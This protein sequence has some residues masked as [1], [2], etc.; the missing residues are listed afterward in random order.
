[1]ETRKKTSRSEKGE[2]GRERI[3]SDEDMIQGFPE[4]DVTVMRPRH[5][6]RKKKVCLPKP[7]YAVDLAPCVLIWEDVS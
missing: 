2:D 4:R 5:T 7:C 3:E 1:M 6:V